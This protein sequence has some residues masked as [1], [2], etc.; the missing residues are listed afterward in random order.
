LPIGA[1]ACGEVKG[2]VPDPMICVGFAA[3]SP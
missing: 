1:L 2:F 3:P